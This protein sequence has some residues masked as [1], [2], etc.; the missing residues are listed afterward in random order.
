MAH[1]PASTGVWL[2]AVRTSCAISLTIALALPYGIKP[3][4]EPR[5]GHPEL[6]RVVDHD[7]IDAAGLLALGTDARPGPSAD[8]RQTRGDL[9]VKPLHDRGA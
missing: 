8:D 3:A 7:Q 4:S 5:P 2:T 1:T 6:A 9:L